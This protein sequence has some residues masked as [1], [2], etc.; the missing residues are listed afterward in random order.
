MRTRWQPGIT[1]VVPGLAG[2]LVMAVVR[3]WAPARA[4][5]VLAE[6]PVADLLVEALEE[7]SPPSGGRGRGPA[8]P[9][10]HHLPLTHGLIEIQPKC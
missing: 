8:V 2:L 7:P 9:V 3:I 4:E 5:E 1:P 6:D 10:R